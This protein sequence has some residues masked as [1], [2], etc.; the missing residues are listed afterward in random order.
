MKIAQERGTDRNVFTVD[1]LNFI[2]RPEARAVSE[3]ERNSILVNEC[4]K[5][6]LNEFL[7]YQESPQLLSC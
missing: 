7:R 3:G 5:R 2:E 4:L 1:I 6:T